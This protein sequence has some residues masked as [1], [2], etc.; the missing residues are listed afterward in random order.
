M[1]LGYGCGS[2]EILNKKS[3]YIKLFYSFSY[4]KHMTNYAYTFVTAKMVADNSPV[5]CC[6]NVFNGSHKYLTPPTPVCPY[7]FLIKNFCTMF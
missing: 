7:R 2:L 4:L 3:I 1:A 6:T 5:V